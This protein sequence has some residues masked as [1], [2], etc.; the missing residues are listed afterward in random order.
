VGPIQVDRLGIRAAAELQGETG[1]GLKAA[2]I[3]HSGACGF[4]QFPV[5]LRQPGI[6]GDDLQIHVGIGPCRAAGS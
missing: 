6:W 5:M 3:I 1:E 2:V 4:E